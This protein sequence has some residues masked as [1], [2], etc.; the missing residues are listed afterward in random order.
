[1]YDALLKEEYNGLQRSILEQNKIDIHPSILFIEMRAKRL[2]QIWANLVKRKGR[3]EKKRAF[4]LK[5]YKYY[6]VVALFF[7]SPIV[8]TIYTLLFRPFTGKSIKRNKN[9]FLYLGIK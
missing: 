7:V 1:V 9:H 5:I 4:W 8:L 2:F 3:D 6:L